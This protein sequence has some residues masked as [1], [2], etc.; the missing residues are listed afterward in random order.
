[1][2]EKKGGNAKRDS[3]EGVSAPTQRHVEAPCWG[4]GEGKGCGGGHTALTHGPEQTSTVLFHAFDDEAFLL[5]QRLLEPVLLLETQPGSAPAPTH[6]GRGGG[7]DIRD[8]PGGKG[9]SPGDPTPVL[10]GDEHG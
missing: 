7:D 9:G 10:R 2:G 6:R 1:M 4:G 3:E 8:P 5:P